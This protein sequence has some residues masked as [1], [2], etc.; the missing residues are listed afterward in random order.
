MKNILYISLFLVLALLFN[1]C[2]TD[3]N[4]E[5]VNPERT[6]KKSGIP[7][8][9]TTLEN[10][11]FE[12]YLNLTGIIKANSQVNVVAEESGILV[13]ILKDKGSRV[14]KGDVLAIL[15]NKVTEAAAEQAEA[16][17]EQAEIDFKSSK[18]LYDKKAISENQFRTAELS[19]KAAKAA[20]DLNNARREKLTIRA[21][22]SGYVITSESEYGR[23]RTI[24]AFYKRRFDR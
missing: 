20:Y 23:C 15:E 21:P 6:T 2:S 24:Y 11:P 1:N 16:V 12:E 8:S 19:L 18:V 7:V 13:E 4:A 3:S 22:I 9:V 10:S 5:N 14:R 17:Y